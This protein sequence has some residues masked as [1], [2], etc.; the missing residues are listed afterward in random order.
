[1]CS[2]YS[3]F[4]ILKE[5]TEI[6]PGMEKHKILHQATFKIKLPILL[7]IIVSSNNIGSQ[8]DMV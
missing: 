8:T 1:M 3:V 4:I 7:R 6:L 2:I 5:G